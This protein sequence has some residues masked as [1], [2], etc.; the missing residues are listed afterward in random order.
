MVLS[1][2]L[3][4]L[5]LNKTASARGPVMATLIIDFGTNVPSVLAGNIVTWNETNGH[6]HYRATPSSDSI[7]MFMNVTAHQSNVW[8]LM[9][10]SAAIMNLTTGSSLKIS[11]EYFSSYGDYYITGI[12]GVQET[13]TL[14]WQYL[15]NGQPALYGVLQ[16]KIADGYVIEW[17]FLPSQ[18]A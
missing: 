18:G 3:Y 14:F 17:Q 9:L 15:V 1:A 12:E 4:G 7:Y 10:A 2:G 6:W 8:S 13:S 5:G 16:Q 11:K